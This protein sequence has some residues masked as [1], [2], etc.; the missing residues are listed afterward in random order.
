MKKFIWIISIL[1]FGNPGLYAQSIE[2]FVYEMLEDQKS[3]LTGANVYQSTTTNG[4]VTDEFGFFQLK[5]KKNDE[6]VIV[7]SFVGYQNDTPGP[8]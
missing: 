1:I 8:C 5:L 4:T 3:P 2:G 6:K 7:I